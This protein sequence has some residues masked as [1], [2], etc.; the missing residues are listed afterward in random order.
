MSDT[1]VESIDPLKHGAISH[2]GV[3]ARHIPSAR[4]ANLGDVGHVRKLI[5]G[6]LALTAILLTVLAATGAAATWTAVVAWV[7]VAVLTTVA[8][9]VATG[10]AGAGTL[11]SPA[12]AHAAPPSW[13]DEL[14]AHYLPDRAGSPFVVKELVSGAAS[15]LEV[16]ELPRSGYFLIDA[17]TQ[18]M[19][20]YSNDAIS[21]LHG[22]AS[23]NAAY[24]GL[25]EYIVEISGAVRSTHSTAHQET[26]SIGLVS[27][28]LPIRS[29]LSPLLRTSDQP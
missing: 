11:L 4:T 6:C 16:W 26:H 1:R 19:I 15:Q 27:E 17:A 12:I 14:L 10:A 13:R 28:R 29:P 21:P 25:G 20:E 3:S 24:L 5:I 22:F 18:A 7:L 23:N 2:N 8:V 9:L